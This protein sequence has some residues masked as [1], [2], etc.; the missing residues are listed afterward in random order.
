M[1]GVDRR[2]Q[3]TEPCVS[4]CRS[5]YP[6]AYQLG[7]EFENSNIPVLDNLIAHIPSG[8][9]MKCDFGKA[10]WLINCNWALG[11]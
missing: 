6:K 11:Q 7:A 9:T 4:C 2:K 3:S 10:S 1:Q 5:V 8:E